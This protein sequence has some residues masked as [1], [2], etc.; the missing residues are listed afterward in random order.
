VCLHSVYNGDKLLD[1]IESD[2]VQKRLINGRYLPVYKL[3]RDGKDSWLGLYFEQKQGGL[4]STALSL[5]HEKDRDYLEN[6]S[7]PDY[8]LGFHTYLTF[9]D[10][11]AEL[12]FKRDLRERKDQAVVIIECLADIKDLLI[13]GTEYFSKVV[14]FR[15]LFVPFYPARGVYYADA[16]EA[17][18]RG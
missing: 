11:F 10:A 12:S 14:V 3:V 2:T 4:V 5:L 9:E 8:W 15:R 17:L 7:A 1:L 18:S 6:R 16:I 13:G